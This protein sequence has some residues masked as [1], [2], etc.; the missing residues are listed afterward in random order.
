MNNYFKFL[1]SILFLISSNLFAQSHDSLAKVY[2]SETIY[3]Y[4]NNFIKGNERITYRNMELEF[5]TPSTK[6]LYKKS[7]SRLFLSKLFTLASLGVT[8]TSIFTP[9]NTSGSIKF[10]LGTGILA[11]VG[12]YYHTQ[13]SK[14]LDKAIWQRNREILFPTSH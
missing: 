6:E 4:G 13:S 3:R 8:T 12:I 2:D 7:K 14:Y 10:A 11:L 1:C 9:T 5:N